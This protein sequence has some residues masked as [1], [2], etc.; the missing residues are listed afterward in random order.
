MTFCVRFQ[1]LSL[2]CR[3]ELVHVLW[4]CNPH[5]CGLWRSCAK[6]NLQ[7]LQQ[8]L[9]RQGHRMIYVDECCDR[10][11]MSMFTLRCCD[12]TYIS[13]FYN[14]AV[15]ALTCPCLFLQ[16]CDSTC[17]STFLCKCCDST[18]IWVLN[19]VEHHMEGWWAWTST[20]RVCHMPKGSLCSTIFRECVKF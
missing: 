11:Y 7:C 16:C 15:I 3:S 12:S 9:G 19:S 17:M 5:P 10:T 4:M 6:R 20:S 2:L 1:L 8:I 13:T 18:F 14:S